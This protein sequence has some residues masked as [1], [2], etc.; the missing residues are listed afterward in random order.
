MRTY[1]QSTFGR[2]LWV[3]VTAAI[4]VAG[5]ATI[6]AARVTVPATLQAQSTWWTIDGIGGMPQGQFTVG[7]YQGKFTRSASRTSFFDALY[8][9]M[10]AS[11]TFELAGPSLGRPLRAD[12]RMRERS[13]TL[14]VV[15]FSPRRLAYR[16]EFTIDDGGPERWFELQE[17]RETLESLGRRTR[18]GSLNQA[19]S[20][21]MVSSLHDLEGAA[22]PLA[23]PAGYLMER[24]GRPMALVELLGLPR[25]LM[26]EALSDESRTIVVASALSLALLWEPERE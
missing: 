20:Q 14:G 9:R 5:C 2:G 3:V 18:I 21:W 22:L 4:V 10:D 1:I 16:C 23:Q 26:D 13:V 11:V 15:S 19:S 17:Q 25:L 7:P 6:Q 24:E 8:E 12:C